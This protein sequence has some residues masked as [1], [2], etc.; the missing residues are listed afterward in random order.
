MK[1]NNRPEEVGSLEYDLLVIGG[2]VNGA[3]SALAAAQKG[4]KVAL[5]EKND[6]ASS[7]SQESSSLAWGGIKYMETYEFGL[8]ASLCRCRN[9]LLKCF[10]NQVREIRFVTTLA[11]GFRKPRILVFLGTLLYWIIGLFFTK[12]PKILNAKA[13]KKR[14][15]RIDVSDSQGGV[16]YSD[17]YFYDTDARFVFN[18]I[19]QAKRLGADCW[20]YCEA[21]DFKL[22]ENRVW[23]VF[24][25]DKL[26]QRRNKICAQYIVNS[27]GPFADV[28]N[29]KLGVKSRYKHVFSKGVHLIVPRI[30][31]TEHVLAFFADDG[32]LFFTIPM[33]NN[34]CIGTTD[35]Q[36]SDLDFGVT[37]EDRRF[38]FENINKRLSL[39]K[40]LENSDIIAERCGVRPL[41]VKKGNQSSYQAGEDWTTLS[42]R[43]EVEFDEQRNVVSIFGGKLTDCLNVGEEVCD[44][45]RSAS[46]KN[47]RRTSLYKY[48]LNHSHLR[49]DF[50]RKC[51]AAGVPEAEA[52]R[53]WRL[54]QE[55][56]LTILDL[57]KDPLN[58]K[59]LV[60]EA[61]LTVAE[62]K[63]SKEFE[64]VYREE[65]FLRRRSTLA[66]SLS[67]EWMSQSQGVKKCLEI[68]L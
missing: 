1:K 8:V 7:T 43:H 56:A 32:R 63:Y 18:L 16:E 34:S 25:E 12:P 33:G 22:N 15:S 30:T 3:V 19:Q 11:K 48:L 38:I 50:Y 24:V 59:V 61:K 9:R 31:E 27:A 6:F 29:E 64:Q 26:S 46:G 13:L 5:V 58:Q 40:P 37:E 21:A 65:D 17:A 52:E 41:V 2:G 44:L 49:H 54:Y 4:L 47:L 42:R 53:W 20:N 39:D 23:E 28:L 35:T 55:G 10:P 67:K 14:E 45:L 62:L 57:W 51:H 66:L 60:P 68:L 36:V